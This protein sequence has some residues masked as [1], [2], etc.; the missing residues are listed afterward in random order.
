VDGGMPVVATTEGR[1][2][3]ARRRYISIAVQDVTDLVRV[4]FVNAGEREFC[5]SFCRRRIKTLNGQWRRVF[6]RQ[7]GE[8][9]KD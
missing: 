6:G 3:F 7:C 8:G 2:K 4:F 5:E 9:R 1:R